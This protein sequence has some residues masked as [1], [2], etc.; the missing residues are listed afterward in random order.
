MWINCKMIKSSSL[1]FIHLFYW[2]RITNLQSGGD[3][4]QFNGT[5]QLQRTGQSIKLWG[6]QSSNQVQF[7]VHTCKSWFKPVYLGSHLYIWVYT[8]K[9]PKRT[10]KNR[11]G[12]KRTK[13]KPKRTEKDRKDTEKDHND[14]EKDTCTNLIRERRLYR[15]ISE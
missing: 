14:T 6:L 13:R 8:W 4:D 12:P 1:D 7:L 2:I 15:F 5:R 10:K 9:R 11:K 3:F